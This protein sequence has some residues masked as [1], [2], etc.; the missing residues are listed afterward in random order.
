MGEI[1]FSELCSE[2][3]PILRKIAKI[4]VQLLEIN[5]Y[6]LGFFRPAESRKRTDRP[7]LV[8]SHYISPVD[9]FCVLIHEYST[10]AVTSPSRA[11]VSSS[12][13]TRSSWQLGITTRLYLYCFSFP[14]Y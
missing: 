2:P 1:S 14:S 7:C 8:L 3:S 13:P 10:A 5:K 12:P 4:A 11:R 9:S 6:V